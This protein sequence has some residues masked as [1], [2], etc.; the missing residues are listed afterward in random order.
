[1]Q[2]SQFWHKVLNRLLTLLGEGRAG[3][4]VYT[5]KVKKNSVKKNKMAFNSVVEKKST[6]LWLFNSS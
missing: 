2:K 3:A 6:L 5:V 4:K 1:M